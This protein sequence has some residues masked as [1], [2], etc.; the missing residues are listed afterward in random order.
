MTPKVLKNTVHDKRFVQPKSVSTGEQVKPELQAVSSFTETV[1]M[2][3]SM[4]PNTPTTPQGLVL[5]EGDMPTTP[6]L[7]IRGPHIHIP[8]PEPEGSLV[9]ELASSTGGTSSS[10]VFG[11]KVMP[12]DEESHVEVIAVDSDSE[13]SQHSEIT[14]NPRAAVERSARE[15]GIRNR[16][17]FRRR[18]LYQVVLNLHRLLDREIRRWTRDRGRT[19]A[20]P[21]S[22][23][24][25]GPIQVQRVCRPVRHPTEMASPRA[26]RIPLVRK[27]SE[28]GN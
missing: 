2:N 17:S 9:K 23:S 10:P 5:C 1:V 3:T 20:D 16:R 7:T 6:T 27:G 19:A 24:P 11:K 18:R 21:E 14:L 12:T 26:R 4:P 22:A 15:R 28:V 25:I 8:S 13:G